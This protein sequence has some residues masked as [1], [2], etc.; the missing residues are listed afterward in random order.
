M[1]YVSQEQAEARAAQEAAKREKEEAADPATKSEEGL[2]DDQER[3]GSEDEDD[4]WQGDDM[5][6]PEGLKADAGMD[7]HEDL[8]R[9]STTSSAASVS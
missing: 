3:G 4:D 7:N 2:P 8:T 6:P 1:S 5:K 9:V